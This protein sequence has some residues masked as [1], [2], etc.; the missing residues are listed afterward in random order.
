M[1][2]ELITVII[3]TYKRPFNMLFKALDSVINQTYSNLEI[4]IVDD[5]PK[6]YEEREI[7]K[8]KIKYLDDKRIKY[9]Q[10]EK[11]MG[12]CAARNTGINAA[13]GNIFM[14]LDD[15]DEW[16][17]T[18]VAEH[19]KIHIRN[20]AQFVYS[21]YK[22]LIISE[23]GTIKTEFV[24]YNHCNYKFFEELLRENFI[25]SVSFVSLTKKCIEECG[26]FTVG[27][28][29][30]QDWDMWIRIIEKNK[31]Y[32][33]DK[34]LVVYYDHREQRITTNTEKQIQGHE[35]IMKKYEKFLSKYPRAMS[36]NLYRMSRLYADAKNYKKS[37]RFWKEANSIKPFVL[38]DSIKAFLKICLRFRIN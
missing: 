23:N 5:S 6:E 22:K 15:D 19:Y 12:A 13:N 18:K 32:F 14:F 25:G 31:A 8:N 9:I 24:S 17:P 36:A 2:E 27:L 35:T 20:N 29:S 34:P 16:M 38:K 1:Q 28:N 4:I 3:T 33:I 37:L 11:N 21:A 26:Y 30:C 10:H 7:I